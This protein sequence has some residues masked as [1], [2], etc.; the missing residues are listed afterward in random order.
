M[1]TAALTLALSCA[2]AWW[3]TH[4]ALVLRNP[5]TGRLY[6]TRWL[7]LRTRTR[8]YFL[9]RMSG[10]DQDRHLHNHPWHA[11]ALILWGGYTERVH[12]PSCGMHAHN[13]HR[14]GD[15]NVLDWRS[16]HKIVELHS[17]PTWT[18]V[19]AGAHERDWG[20]WVDGRHVPWRTYL[21]L[22]ADTKLED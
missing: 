10:P 18:I 3:W 4:P 15:L 7:L 5:E 13:R 16:Y 20:F 21:G 14:A 19:R 6:L 17:T 1:I 11:T 12:M 8:R 9:H 22:P 2:F